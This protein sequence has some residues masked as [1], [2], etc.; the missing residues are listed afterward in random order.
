MLPTTAVH[1]KGEGF[2]SKS[3]SMH[4]VNIQAEDLGIVKCKLY[5]YH[6]PLFTKLILCERNREG[7]YIVF[8]SEAECVLS[9]WP[10]NIVCSMLNCG[11]FCRLYYR[12]KEHLINVMINYK[13]K[14]TAVHIML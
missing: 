10:V 3:C 6:A 1:P 4:S 8:F 11:G 9:A 12:Y 2:A 14:Y 13:C 5:R 7:C